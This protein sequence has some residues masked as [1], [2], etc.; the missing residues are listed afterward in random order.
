MKLYSASGI[1]DFIICLGYKGHVTKD[2]FVNYFL[3]SSDQTVDLAENHL[4]FHRNSC[5]PW[6]VTLVDTGASTMTGGRLKRFL[7]FVKN[8]SAFCFTYGDG[9]A[10]VNISELI[11]FHAQSGGL[12]TLA[13]TQP[14]G[15]L[16]APQI[17]DECGVR[18]LTE[19]PRGDGRW[20]IGGSFVLSPC[21]G[22]Y[23]E[24]DST[25]WEGKTR[26]SRTEPSPSS[27]TCSWEPTFRTHHS[28]N[29]H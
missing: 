24:G 23:F 10:N 22:E 5:E 20:V 9:L 17:E 4:E 25:V 28:W 21:V 27:S 6:R 11:S 8:D 3:Y 26:S 19:K 15:N 1:N 7:P 13:A 18:T 2:F 12:A 16:G 14:V 29:P